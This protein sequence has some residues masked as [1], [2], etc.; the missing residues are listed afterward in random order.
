MRTSSAIVV[1]C[2]LCPVTQAK[3]IS[4]AKEDAETLMM[5]FDF[6]HN[7]KLDRKE[8]QEL[9]DKIGTPGAMSTD[10]AFRL[11]D[12]DEDGNVSAQEIS[13]FVQG[14]A[15]EQAVHE[16]LRVRGPLGARKVANAMMKTFDANSSG[17]LEMSE[18]QTF[19]KQAN[20]VTHDVTV[21]IRRIDLDHDGRLS[22]HEITDFLVK[23]SINRSDE[24]RKLQALLRDNL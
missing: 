6:D 18:V 22:G 13:S 2:L 17:F 14:G 4:T 21:G 9:S 20:L 11:L 10:K 19:A 12:A 7:N 23:R 1:L 24:V 8:F 3:D 16:Q 5:A 15:L